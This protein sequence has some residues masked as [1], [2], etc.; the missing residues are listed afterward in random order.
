MS[1]L[2]LNAYCSVTKFTL[3]WN[4]NK[5]DM[6]AMP[7]FCIG[8]NQAN[9]STHDSLQEKGGVILSGAD[10]TYIL[11]PPQ[12]A[13]PEVKLHEE[14]LASI[15][16]KLNCS[17]MK[18]YIK[19]SKE[20]EIYHELRE[21]ANIPEGFTEGEDGTTLFGRRAYGVP[22]GSEVFVTEWLKTK[23]E[24]IRSKSETCWIRI[25]LRVEIFH[26]VSASGSSL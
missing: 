16:L 23:G 14:R 11:G 25:G 15:G 17:K 26:R 20:F 7:N 10:D 4:T 8:I 5:G 22:I 12:I 9:K 24:R 6:E 3:F 18:C 13:F 1:F 19:E 2:D 21:A